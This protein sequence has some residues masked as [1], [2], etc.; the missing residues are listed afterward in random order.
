MLEW[1]PYIKKLHTLR[2][3]KIYHLFMAQNLFDRVPS[4]T[5]YSIQEH[6]TYVLFF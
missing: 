5:K 6:R 3:I 4:I 1:I 2:V